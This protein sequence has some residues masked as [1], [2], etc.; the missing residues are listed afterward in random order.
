MRTVRLEI[1]LVSALLTAARFLGPESHFVN[2]STK[3]GSMLLVASL[4][5]GVA[6][7]AY[8]SP[9]F[10]PGPGYSDEILTNEHSE[11]EWLAVLLSDYADW[12]E[13]TERLNYRNALLL[14]ACQVLLIVGILLLTYGI[15]PVL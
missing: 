12:I 7:Y 14:G 9:D 15:F 1:V 2:P 6:T 13:R 3:Y 10:G 11:H 8:S 4:M 5:T